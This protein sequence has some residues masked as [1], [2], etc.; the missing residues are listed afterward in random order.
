MKFPAR[1]LATIAFL[2][3]TGFAA[4]PVKL[5]FDTDM[6]NDCDDAGALAVLNALADKGEVAILAITT[7]RNCPGNASGAAADAINTWYGRPDIPIGSDKDAAKVSW[8]APSSFTPTLHKDFPNDSPT[9]DQ[10]PDALD[11]YREALSSQPDKSVV[12]CSVG[13]LSN[14][15][16]LWRAEPDLVK[17][18]VKELFIMGGGF[19][20]TMKGE[21]NIKLD[22]A[23]AVTIT[24]EWPTPIVWQGYEV[25]AAMSNGA[26]LQS[27]PET[28]PVRRAY[29]LRPFHENKAI[30]FGKP[31]HDLATVLL[32][33][34]G[35]EDQYWSVGKPG[36]VVV[37]SDGN[38]RWETDYPKKH[39]YVR[40]KGHVSKLEKI[41]GDLLIAPPISAQ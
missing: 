9:D 5:I 8:K 20:R 39:R 12:I 40:I 37:D 18:K 26:E 16:D 19:P 3:S 32:A 29:E 17:A 2:C 15:E 14:L 35:I 23:A 24:N 25:G 41:L 10:L 28:N 30:T 7:N 13:A 27:A 22:P 31:N 38:T 33:V 21:T 34:R 6:A 4:E 1:L 11:V 36:R